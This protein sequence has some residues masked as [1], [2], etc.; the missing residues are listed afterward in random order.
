MSKVQKQDSGDSSEDE[1]ESIKKRKE[2]LQKISLFKFFKN[3]RCGDQFLL[4]VGTISAILAG[5]LMPSVSFV[6]GNVAGSF[7]GS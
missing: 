5:G 6:M 4:I 2:S 1:L 7:S 3:L